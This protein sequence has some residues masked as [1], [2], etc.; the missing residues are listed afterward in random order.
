MITHL[1]LI[2]ICFVLASFGLSS[3]GPLV[4]D[5]WTKVFVGHL[6]YDA[7]AASLIFCAFAVSQWIGL[8]TDI[9]SEKIRSLQM[10]LASIGLLALVIAACAVL[11][12]EIIPAWLVIVLIGGGNA[13]IAGS[14]F[15]RGAL[16]AKLEREYLAS[17][18]K[19]VA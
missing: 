8:K 15:L 7:L 9:R 5:D 19:F 17:E 4:W 12:N 18:T 13:L 14:F 3:I 1:F 16:N 2:A 11:A 6:T 10:L